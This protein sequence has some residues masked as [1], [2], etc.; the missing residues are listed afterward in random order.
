MIHNRIQ[1]VCSSIEM[2]KSQKPFLLIVDDNPTN[3]DVLIEILQHSYE[4]SIMKSGKKALS[5]IRNSSPDLILLDIHMPEMNGMEVCEQIKSD[6][7]T[8]DIPV[9]FISAQRDPSDIAKIFSVGGADYFFKP[10]VPIEVKH[11]IKTQI[12]LFRYRQQ[13]QTS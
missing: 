9:I 3:L 13:A 10:F 1:I 11:K 5:F 8:R 2:K 7:S 12:E 6:D 4:I